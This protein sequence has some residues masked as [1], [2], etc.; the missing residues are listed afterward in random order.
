MRVSDP[1]FPGKTF[2]GP[3]KTKDDITPEDINQG[4][5]GN[6]W[7][8]AAISALAEKEHRISDYI[9]SDA[10]DMQNGIYAMNFFSL[11]VPN[12]M[13]V[14]DRMPMYGPNTIFANMGKDGSVWGAIVEKAFAK[15]YGNYQHLVGGWM[16]YAVSAFNG[17]PFIEVQHNSSNANDIW[18][19]LV[20]ADADHDIITAGSNFCGS[21]DNST[22]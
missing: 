22:E 4:Y 8:M 19:L 1:N 10:I 14:D 3:G 6:C 9:V 2:W 20:A 13:I 17:S 15:Y 11:G 18:D 7:I 21:H 12:T 16:A 5:I